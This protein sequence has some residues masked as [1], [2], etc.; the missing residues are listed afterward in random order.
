MCLLNIESLFLLISCWFPAAG[1]TKTRLKRTDIRN[2]PSESHMFSWCT[3]PWGRSR[4]DDLPPE[5]V[6]FTTRHNNSVLLV[7]T[8]NNLAPE[9]L[10]ETLLLCCSLCLSNTS[11]ATDDLMLCLT[12]HPHLCFGELFPAVPGREGKK[13]VSGWRGTREEMQHVF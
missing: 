5:A 2:Q 11:G 12:T 6:T 4:L 13:R 7:K 8:L 3:S 1:V 9:S 10:K